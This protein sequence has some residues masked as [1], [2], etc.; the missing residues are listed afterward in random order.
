MHLLL[1]LMALF[2]LVGQ[3]AAYAMAPI[4]A[5]A[6]AAAPPVEGA[7]D[8]AE[9]TKRHDTPDMPCKG[10]TFECIAKMGC[11]A[12]PLLAPDVPLGYLPVTFER[13]SY[14]LSS[15]SHHSLSV[16]PELFPPIT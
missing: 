12:P 10:I 11:L 14:A 1:V 7:M 3:T 4:A 8:C 15:D 13:V 5:S 16:K 2:G 9:M 6:E